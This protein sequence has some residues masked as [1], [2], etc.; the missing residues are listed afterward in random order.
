MSCSSAFWRRTIFDP[1]L[2]GRG[3][4]VVLTLAAPG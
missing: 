2:A 4:F 1:V 3:L